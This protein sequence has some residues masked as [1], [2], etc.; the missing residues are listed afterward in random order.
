[1]SDFFNSKYPI[2][3]PGMYGCSD[4]DLA[5]AVSKAGC[6]PSIVSSSENFIDELEKCSVGIPNKEFAVCL[7]SSKADITNSNY[8]EI[9]KK[10]IEVSPKYIEYWPS[11]KKT[12]MG[13]STNTGFGDIEND[14]QVRDLLK[15]LR[16]TSKIIM[17][18][19]QP[20]QSAYDDLIDAYSLKSNESAGGFGNYSSLELLAEYKKFTNK[21]LIPQGGIGTSGQIKELLKNGAVAAGIGTRFAVSIESRL[22]ENAKIMI[23]NSTVD[24]LTI[25]ED[26]NQRVLLFD[27]DMDLT[28]EGSDWNR[29]NHLARGIKTG[30]TGLVY[31][32][33]AI[34][35]VTKITSVAEIVAEL[36]KDL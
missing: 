14:K 13:V 7:E 12:L 22:S 3:V 11:K 25:L 1:M 5:I 27:K 23:V 19:Y 30:K 24:N 8:R 21:P 17:R 29:C 36:V 34:N 35:Q 16:K 15:L 18:V 32:G 31:V 20:E 4:A 26:T 6:V 33:N 10:I 28:L 2:Y 9:I